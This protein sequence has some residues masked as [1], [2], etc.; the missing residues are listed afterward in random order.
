MGF[1]RVPYISREDQQQ[2]RAAIAADNIPLHILGESNTLASEDEIAIANINMRKQAEDNQRKDLKARKALVDLTNQV[3]GRAV[4]S[5]ERSIAKR[6]KHSSNAK[7]DKLVCN[8]AGA[9]N[10]SARR[11]KI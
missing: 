3:D 5:S 1:R 6:H 2:Q 7:A 9:N 4:V 11:K 10:I 8:D